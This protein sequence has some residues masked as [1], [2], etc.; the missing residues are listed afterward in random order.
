V[1]APIHAFANHITTNTSKRIYRYIF[2][3]RNPFPNAPFYQQAHHWVD[4]YFLFRAMQFRYSHQWL[5]DVSD[6]HAELWIK[7]ACGNAPW[8]EYQTGAEGIVMVADERE[9]WVEKTLSQYDSM[10][11][12]E[13]QR[14]ESLWEAC[15]EKKGVDWA[16]IDLAALLSKQ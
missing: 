3:T 10:S 12:T 16:P 2:D 9:G 6:R 5:K 11:R 15:S 1:I 13:Y 8:S 14:L 7:F 4:V